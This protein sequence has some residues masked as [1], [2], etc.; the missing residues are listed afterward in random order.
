M[1]AQ[2]FKSHTLVFIFCLH[3]DQLPPSS[4]PPSPPQSCPVLG[5]SAGLGV[6]SVL[7]IISLVGNTVAVCRTL[8]I[9]KSLNNIEQ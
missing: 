3:V 7:L 9:K 2:N 4:V 8:C 5:Y 6:V 1:N